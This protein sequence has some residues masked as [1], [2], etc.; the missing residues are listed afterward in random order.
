MFVSFQRYKFVWYW[1][2]ENEFYNIEQYCRRMQFVFHLDAFLNASVGV[3]TNT[4]D[5]V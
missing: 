2:N 4:E 3:R 5:K 1:S